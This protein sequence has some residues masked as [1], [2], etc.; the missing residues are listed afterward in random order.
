[1]N[2]YEA[3]SAMLVVSTASAYKFA[4]DVLLSLTGSKPE[5]DLDAPLMLKEATNT[6]IPSPLLDALSKKPIHTDVYGKDKH[7]M[8]EAVFSFAIG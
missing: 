3:K 7:S 5:N 1:M 6:E 4:G 8:A 2:D